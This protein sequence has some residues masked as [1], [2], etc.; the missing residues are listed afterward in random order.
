MVKA[1][2]L[3]NTLFRATPNSK[4]QTVFKKLGFTFTQLLY[5][6]LKVYGYHFSIFNLSLH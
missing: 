4:E 6:G 1:Y 5:F 2:S 3:G